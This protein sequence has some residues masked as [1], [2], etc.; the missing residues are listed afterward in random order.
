MKDNLLIELGLN[1][2]DANAYRLLLL[3][4]QLKPTDLQKFNGETRVN[5][6]AILNRLLDFGLAVKIVENKKTVYRANSPLMLE[7]LV[8]NNIAK[9]QMKLKKIQ[10][11]LPK[12][13]DEFND[14]KNNPKIKLYSGK[15]ELAEMYEI[16]IQQKDRNLYFIRSIADIAFL[17]L[18]KMQE[19]RFLAPKYHKRRF[20]ITPHFHFI[21]GP[22]GDKKTNLKRTWIPQEDYPNPV[23]WVVSGNVIHAMVLKG[24]GYG[25][26]IEHPEIAESFRQILKNYAKSIKSNPSYNPDPAVLKRKTK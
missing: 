23:E 14:R 13:M 6:Y 3:R 5:C 9:E 10:S 2:K 22:E 15:E 8:L 16:Q 26:S 25:V 12:L 17:G 1:K 24:E 19:V 4:G 21:T 11:L 20:G 18:K 7:D